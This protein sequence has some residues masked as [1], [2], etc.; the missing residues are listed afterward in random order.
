MSPPERAQVARRRLR[1]ALGQGK[2]NQ[3]GSVENSGLHRLPPNLW[4]TSV[5]RRPRTME[6]WS[7]VEL[8][9]QQWRKTS[10]DIQLE[11][12]PVEEPGPNGGFRLGLLHLPSSAEDHAAACYGARV[13][14]GYCLSLRASRSTGA[15]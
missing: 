10:R 15:Q 1:V 12:E 8:W 14:C 7:R 2:G 4:K 6:C 3:R 5:T 9:V 11:S 13:L